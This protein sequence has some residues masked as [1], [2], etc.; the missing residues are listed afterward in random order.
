MRKV[1]LYLAVMALSGVMCFTSFAGEWK[2]DG[3]GYWYQN[4]DGSYPVNQWKDIEGKQYFFGENGYMLSNITTPDGKQVGSDGAMVVTQTGNG[5][6]E[7]PYNSF[8]PVDFS[9]TSKYLSNYNYSARLQL[10]EIVDGIKASETVFSENRFNDTQHGNY[11]WKLYHFE[12][13]CLSS[14][15]DYIS[16]SII[17]PS[18]FFNH[19]STIG[20]SDIK[21]AV[22]G[23][24][25]KDRYDIKL[26]PGGTDDFWVGILLD[27]RI[28]HITF[29]ID[30]GDNGDIWFS[31]KK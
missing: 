17:N 21:T 30:T 12:L 14:A 6:R 4:D 31:T 15:G 7:N 25:L 29:K 18:D 2:Q 20:L 27:D 19:D 8:L 1:K 5:T 13:S 24:E 3:Q 10:L 26:Y 23:D 9:H 11:K 16:G 22:L 28:P